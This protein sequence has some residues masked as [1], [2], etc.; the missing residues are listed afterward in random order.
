MGTQRACLIFHGPQT[1]CTSPQRLMIIPFEYGTSIPYVPIWINIFF[2]YAQPV[3]WK[4]LTSK[5]LKGHTSYV[6]CINY[7]TEGTQL[8]SGGC[9]GDLRIWNAAKGA[10]RL[11]SRDLWPWID[12]SMQVDAPKH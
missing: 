9:D 8:V 4:G 1:V 5:V 11:L 6:F 2:L 3:V 12:N 7:N 10:R